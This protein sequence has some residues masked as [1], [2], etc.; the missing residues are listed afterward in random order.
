MTPS[1]LAVGEG[2]QRNRAGSRP[3]TLKIALSRKCWSQARAMAISSSGWASSG[4]GTRSGGGVSG[5]AV[6]RAGALRKADGR[7]RDE[8]AAAHRRVP[9][10]DGRTVGLEVR[11]L[12]EGGERGDEA[13]QA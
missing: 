6:R 4:R 11:V 10:G 13:L 2:C 3:S 5:T 9:V 7:R 8:G 1:E 12:A